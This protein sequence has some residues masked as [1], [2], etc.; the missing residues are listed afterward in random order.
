MISCLRRFFNWRTRAEP[1]LPLVF[2]PSRLGDSHRFI[3]GIVT[4]QNYY[5]STWSEL[6][7]DAL[8]TIYAA[9]F[10]ILPASMLEL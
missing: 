4:Q 1:P 7:G 9:R 6:T 10:L 8:S 2:L 3:R 5:Y